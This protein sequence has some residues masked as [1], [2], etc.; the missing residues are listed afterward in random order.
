MK[1]FIFAFFMVF[2]TQ[3]VF[4]NQIEKTYPLNLDN[5]AN[6][7]FNHTVGNIHVRFVEPNVTPHPTL[8]AR[9]E[10][11]KSGFFRKKTPLK[12]VDLHIEKK[13][14]TLVIQFDADKVQANLFLELPNHYPIEKL[15]MQ[16]DIG[17]V[18]VENLA[19]AAKIA[20]EIGN[21]QISSF[22]REVGSISMDAEIGNT[23]LIGVKPILHNRHYASSSLQAAGQGQHSIELSVDI[24]NIKLQLEN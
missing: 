9:F 14:D 21:I 15:N 3:S 23:N 1:S 24:G 8:Y 6:L 10:S 2:S 20:V 12:Q 19:S 17:N 5:I 22:F 16:V 7:T 4:A 11:Q 18:K 13:Q